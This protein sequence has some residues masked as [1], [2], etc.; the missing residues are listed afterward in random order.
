MSFN[1][2]KYSRQIFIFSSAGKPIY[3]LGINDQNSLSLI[4]SSL[5]AILSKVTYILSGQKVI[6]FNVE[7]DIYIFDYIKWM[8]SDSHR[9]VFLERQGII[10]CCIS[11]FP[12]DPI[13]Y[14]KGVLEYVY[15]QLIMLLTGSI[16]K[17]LKARPNIDIQQ[18][19][20]TSDVNIINRCIKSVQTNIDSLYWHYSFQRSQK[21]NRH[22]KRNNSNFPTEAPN[23]FIESQPLDA[24]IRSQIKKLIQSIKVD[25]LLGGVMFA[26]SRIITWFGS[27][28]IKNMPSTDFSLLRNITYSLFKKEITSNELWIPICLP[29]ISTMSYIYCY[30]HYWNF[31]DVTV[32]SSNICL[33]LLSSNSNTHVFEKLSSHS[34]ACLNHIKNSKYCSIFESFEMSL[35]D[36]NTLIKNGQL[37]EAIVQHFVYISTYKNCYISSKTHPEIHDKK[38]VFQTYIKIIEFTNSQFKKNRES[39]MHT[40]IN[41]KNNKFINIS[42]R[43]FHLLITLPLNAKIDRNFLE[44]IIINAR[45]ND[46]F[47]FP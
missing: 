8:C 16:H 19:I 45:K 1:M 13:G 44:L 27:K 10:L 22:L 46:K 42:N 37:S 34:N 26:S 40:I 36:P 18:M 12:S 33:V 25:G 6:L 20:G 32:G 35:A 31:N 24:E 7:K 28:Y 11:Q 9:I 4:S 21:L 47:F 23:L 17:S 15:Y 30:L 14:L 43:D 5:S 41:M 29:C 3:S 39:S 2:K 38:D